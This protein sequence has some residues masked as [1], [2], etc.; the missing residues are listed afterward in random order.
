RHRQGRHKRRCGTIESSRRRPIRFGARR[1]ACPPKKSRHE[2]RDGRHEC[3]RHVRLRQMLDRIREQADFCLVVP[4]YNEEEMLP[5]LFRAAVPRLNEAIGPRWRI[6][7]VDDG[8]AD[9]T[10][11][12]IAQ[13]HLADE[14]IVGVRLSRNFGHQAAV[15]VGLAFAAG[16]YVGVIDCD[17]Q[18]PI[19][20]LVA[21]YRKAVDEKLDVCYGIRGKRDA[22]LFL[23]AA[24]SL[25]YRIIDRLAD[26]DWPR[27]TGDF[28]VMSSR[29]HKVLTSLPEHSRMMRG[30]RAWVGFRQDGIRYDRPARLH[31]QTKYNLRRLC[32]LAMQG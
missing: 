18:D 26:H 2:C 13:E 12:I 23:R 17:L 10:F 19:E 11:A 16:N 28:C 8:S 24:Y 21:M 29:C 25:F 14:R 9:A 32:A 22:S 27:D 6:L 5:A 1:P 4:C 31:G 3:P 7:C 15:S 20:V 30:L